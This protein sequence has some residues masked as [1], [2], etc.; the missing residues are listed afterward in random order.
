MAKSINQVML[1]GRLTRDPEARSTSTGKQI[2]SFGLAVGRYNS[3]EADFFEVDAWEKLAELVQQYVH[4]GS[5]VI[6][7]G[8]LQFSQWEKDGKKSS[9]V[10]IVATDV[11]FLDAP[12]DGDAKKNDRVEN[13]FDAL[14]QAG[15]ISKKGTNPADEPIDLSE[16]PF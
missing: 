3:D 9:K 5:K 1:L 16:I 12:S 2:S 4:K 11:T 8:R 15:Q 14:E 6:V 7:Q 13:Q 10:T